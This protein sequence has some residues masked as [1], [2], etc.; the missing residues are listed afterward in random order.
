M[1]E[2][3]DGGFIISGFSLSSNTGTLTGLTGNGNQ[4]FWIIK[5]NSAGAIEWQQLLGGS[6]TD[7]SRSIHQTMDGGFIVT[8][9]SSSSNTGTLAGLT[10]HGG[11]DCWI[12]KLDD[13]GTILWQKLFGGSLADVAYR[14]V[15]VQDGGYV[16]FGYALS[17]N[18]GTLSGLTNNGNGDYWMMKLDQSGVIVWQKLFGGTLEDH[19]TTFRKT[20]DDGFIL[21]GYSLSSD[22]GN[23]QGLMNH[24]DYDCWIFKIDANGNQD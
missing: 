22:T 19:G 11:T 1:Q 8:G 12:L 9:I 15:Q 23:L 20:T 6:A 2:T 24:G 5:L 18:T 17:S 7:I 4:D 13:S 21:S 16:V 3:N 10:T 14:A